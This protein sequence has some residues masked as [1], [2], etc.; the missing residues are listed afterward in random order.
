MAAGFRNFEIPW[1]E[2]VFAGAPQDSNAAAFGTLGINF[3]ANK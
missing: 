3:R 1:R 2:D